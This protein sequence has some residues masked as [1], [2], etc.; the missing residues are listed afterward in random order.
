VLAACGTVGVVLSALAA[1]AGAV[2]PSLIQGSGSSWAVPALTIWI[3]GIKSAGVQVVYNPDGDAAGRQD[4]A[5]KVSDFAVTSDGYLG[6]T[7]LNGTSD[8]SNGRQYAYLPIAAGGTAFAYHI[9]VDGTQVR[10]LRLS[11]QTLAKIFTGQITNWDNATIT[12]NNNGVQLPSLPIVPVVQS[13]GSGATEQLTNY[14]ARQFPAIWQPYAGQPGPTEYYPVNGVSGMQPVDGS[15]S[16][17]NYVTSSEGNG[18]IAYVEYSYALDVGY[19]VVKVL[20]SAGYYTLP[21]KYNVAVSL[22]AAV[23]NMNQATQNYLLQTLDN[24]FTDTDPRTYPLSSYVYMIEPTGRYPSPETK[25]TTGKRQSLA[26]FEYFAICQGQTPI[27]NIGYSP[28]PV[29]LVEAG[30]GQLNRLKTVAPAIGITKE[31]IYNCNNPTFVPGQPNENYLAQIAPMPPACD[32]TGAG[33]CGATVTPNGLGSTPN[34]SGTYGSSSSVSSPTASGG[35]TP[36]STASGGTTPGT[37]TTSRTGASSAGSTR[38]GP[39]GASSSSSGGGSS[40]VK[41]VGHIA[42]V[43]APNATL[44]SASLPDGGLSAFLSTYG[45]LAAGLLF[46]TFALPVAVGYRRS[47]RRRGTTS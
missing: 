15:S 26:D 30:F 9:T 5:N 1:P 43:D 25:I 32:Q 22:E 2:N 11:G 27:S 21:T 38:A 13:Q 46:L 6:F 42:G 39:A 7:K 14:F 37:S 31:T 45:L 34:K 44:V 17:I 28:L 41:G 18:S 19:P 16:A 35:T 33:P 20:N 3:G 10:T 8:T 24:V 36:G 4:F 40:Q 23:I 47:R 12:K 29:N